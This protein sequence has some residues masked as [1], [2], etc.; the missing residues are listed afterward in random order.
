MVV[1][2][3]QEMVF[4][5]VVPAVTTYEYGSTVIKTIEEILEY[6]LTVR[7]ERKESFDYCDVR[8]RAVQNV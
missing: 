6:S 3:L 1:P 5:L 2:L 8:V 4:V 7:V